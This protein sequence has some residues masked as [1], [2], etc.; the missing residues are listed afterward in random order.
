MKANKC[1]VNSRCD[2]GSCLESRVAQY[3]YIG[4]RIMH[5]L[6][7]RFMHTLV[8]QTKDLLRLA[9]CVQ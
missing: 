8:V 4:L 1:Q 3:A 9:L 6:G 7:L 2:Y 5:T